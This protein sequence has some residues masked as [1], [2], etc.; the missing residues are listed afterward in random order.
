[1]VRSVTATCAQVGS[2]PPVKAF[3]QAP[4]G[5]LWWA[6]P[7]GACHSNTLGGGMVA[8]ADLGLPKITQPNVAAITNGASF[9]K[10]SLIPGAI[11]TAFGTNLTSANDINLASAL[12]L[13]NSLVNS[14]VLVNGCAATPLFAVDNV[15]NSQQINFQVPWEVAGQQTVTVQVMN[16]GVVSQPVDVPV[17]DSQPGVFTYSVGTNLF[18]AVLHADYSLA[19]S[20]HPATGGETVLIYL[21]GMGAASTPQ[22]DGKAAN[23]EPTVAVPTVTIGGK[24]AMVAYSG[25]APGFV[26]LNQINVQIPS[27]LAPGNQPVLVSVGDQLSNSTLLPVK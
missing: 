24:P 11:A 15:N 25:L 10:G 27:G 22:V 23:G 9:V 8:S 3:V 6:S 1:M 14:T 7:A 18:G 4:D 19:D 12:P 21:T 13:P 2:L 5:Q 20:A 26:G 17:A 16:N